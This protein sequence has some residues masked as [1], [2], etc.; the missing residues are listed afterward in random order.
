MPFLTTL[1]RRTQV[2]RVE[3]SRLGAFRFHATR[4]CTFPAQPSS[5]RVVASDSVSDPFRRWPCN[6]SARP[7]VSR[8]CPHHKNKKGMIVYTICITDFLLCSNP[9]PHPD[10]ITTAFSSPLRIRSF[11]PSLA[12]WRPATT[13]ELRPSPA[14]GSG[15]PYALGE[16]EKSSAA[17]LCLIP[18]DG[19]TL[20]RL[21]R[22]RSWGVT[23]VR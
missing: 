21:G 18:C 17:F 14:V 3:R 16:R 22:R 6:A 4:E 5:S 2:P 11:V 15:Q 23:L 7:A 1:N 19:Q 13:G 9:P 8:S 20:V 12:A 10:C